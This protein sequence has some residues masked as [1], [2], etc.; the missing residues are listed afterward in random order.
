MKLKTEY[1]A[2]TIWQPWASL[3]TMGLKP[4]EFRDWPPPQYIVDF[5]MAIHAGKRPVRPAEI[6]R[7]L[8]FLERGGDDAR[9][10]GLVDHDKA[11]TFLRQVLQAPAMLPTSRILAI[12]TVG[13]GISNTSL[14]MALGLTPGTLVN[15]SDRDEHTRWGWPLRDIIPLPGMSQT[16]VPGHQSLWPWKVPAALL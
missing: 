1:S 9:A 5:Q 10:T 2:L 11:I 8:Y 16:A 12:A 15:D 3:I 7:L 6:R 13:Q 14:V 4:W